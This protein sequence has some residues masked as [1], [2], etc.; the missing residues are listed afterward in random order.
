MYS[1]FIFTPE[2]TLAREKTETMLAHLSRTPTRTV[3]KRLT[4]HLYSGA[5]EWR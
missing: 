3:C 5:T 1:H 4:Q 2:P